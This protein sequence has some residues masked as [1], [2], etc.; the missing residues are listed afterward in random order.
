VSIVAVAGTG[1]DV[2]KTFVSAA[3]LRALR[4][5]GSA[6]AAR[7]PV[8]SFA[9]DDRATDAHML[10]EATGETPYEVCPPHR[11]LKVPLA[12]PI[13]AEALGLAPFSITD[14]AS[15]V[16]AH[17]PTATFTL[18][19]TAGGVRS[20]LADDGDCAAFI[21]A[22]SPSLVVLVADA[23]LGTINSVR[24]SIDAL[25]PHP[26]IVYLN[27]FTDTSDVHVGNAEWLR[28]REGLDVVTDIEALAKRVEPLAR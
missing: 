13:A 21:A 28:T 20:P 15:E 18:V 9:P 2:G 27:R 10:A 22:L 26:V 25:R 6:V 24:M 23:G 3:V 14:L 1:T 16:L 5:H 19:E 12:P 8:Q 11:W 4:A 7:K 17:V